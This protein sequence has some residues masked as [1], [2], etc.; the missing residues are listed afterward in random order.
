MKNKKPIILGVLVVVLVA[1]IGIMAVLIKKYA[2]NK[3][4]MNLAEYFKV[5]T[6]EG[7]MP[8]ILEDKLSDTTAIMQ[9]DHVYVN[10]TFVKSEL[11]KRFYWDANEN[12]LLYTTSTQVI[13]TSLNSKDCYIN[14]SK[15][16]EDF[17]LA[18]A[19]GDE[20]YIALDYVKMYTALDY[21]TYSKPDRVVIH[22]V[23]GEDIEYAKVADETQLRYK[24]S[25]KS[26]ILQ[27][28]KKDDVVRILEKEDA[29]TGFIK[30]LSESGVTGYIQSKRMGDAY[31]EQAETDFKEEK[32]THILMDKQVNLVWHQV[33]NQTANSNLSSMLSSTKGVNVVSPTWF[34]TTDNNGNIS[35]LASDSYVDTAHRAGVQVW[36]LCSDFGPKMKI[37]KVLGSTSKR[38]KLAKNLMAEAIRYS[39]D[40]INIDFENVKKE[41]GEDFVQFIR[42]LG[43]MCR[44]NGI[45]LSIDNYPPMGNLTNYYDREEQA[46]VADYVIT[47]A[48][49]EHYRGGESA[50]PVS[51]ISYVTN[52]IKEVSKEVPAEQMV[53]ALPFY[54][55]HWKEK[56]KDGKVDLDCDDCSMKG[57]KEVVSNSGKKATWDDVAGTNYVEYTKDGVVHKIWVEDAKSLELKLKAVADAKVGGVAFWKMGLEE[58][59]VWNMIEKY[60]KN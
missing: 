3:T 45:V 55:R 57:A 50:G 26:Q 28:V 39:L 54:S 29:E 11:N 44:N 1:V 34:M 20:V 19:Q 16:S 7:K 58:K 38:Q 18:I 24:K 4:H 6:D 37:G 5:A 40:G 10:V 53:I 23:Y 49:D 59:S 21:Q 2:P 27:D 48:Y 41:S 15:E 32:Y 33:T 60:V 17:V 22:N 9:D 43:I 35:S 51:S 12:Q 25:I 31:K 42:E 47:M 56:T 13:S 36:A 46:K 52:S 30:V 14:K 8:V